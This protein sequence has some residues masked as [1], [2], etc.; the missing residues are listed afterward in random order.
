MQIK[1]KS[2]FQSN[3]Q[4]HLLG[5]QAVQCQEAKWK[6]AEMIVGLIG[7]IIL[8]L[9]LTVFVGTLL[10]IHLFVH[11]EKYVFGACCGPGCV[12]DA[13]DLGLGRQTL[14]LSK[15]WHPSREDR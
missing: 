7:G 3:L 15:G 6:L 12:L 1:E 11:S 13:G 9:I 4:N 8:Y 2:E 5:I 10:K 14:C